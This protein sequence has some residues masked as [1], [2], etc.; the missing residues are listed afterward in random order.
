M[1]HEIG[2]VRANDPLPSYEA[3]AS[4]SVTRLQQ[5]VYDALIAQGAV[6]PNDLWLTV[7]QLEK[8]LRPQGIDKWSI[9]PR[10]CGLRD[11]KMIE[12]CI[13]PGLNSSGKVRNLTHHRAIK[14]ARDERPK[15]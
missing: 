11:Q 13:K 1:T 3:A 7:L 14:G 6:K 15:R 4:I 5:A 10:M 2:G 12:S 9:S 8:I